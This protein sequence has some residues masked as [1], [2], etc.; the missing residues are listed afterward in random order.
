MGHCV[1]TLHLLVWVSE[2]VSRPLIDG[3]DIDFF[4]IYSTYPV[5]G[6][7]VESVSDV[8]G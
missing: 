2:H 7:S 3:Q 5:H 1:S 8:R 4:L 6:C